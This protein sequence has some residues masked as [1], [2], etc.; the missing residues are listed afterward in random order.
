MLPIPKY[1]RYTF[2]S[3]Q[4]ALRASIHRTFKSTLMNYIIFGIIALHLIAGFGWLFY[5]LEF[6]KKKSV[7]REE[8]DEDEVV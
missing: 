4:K 2:A 1:I 3:G 8:N 6:Q 5:K 7:K